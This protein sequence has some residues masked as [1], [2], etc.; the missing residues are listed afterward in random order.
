MITPTETV[1]E[2]ADHSL[3]IPRVPGYLGPA[4]VLEF[5]RRDRLVLVQWEDRGQS[6][7]SWAAPALAGDYQFVA[8]DIVLVLSQNLADFY[9]TGLLHS[10]LGRARG[11]SPSSIRSASGAIA[12]VSRDAHAETLAVRSPR[13]E[14]VFEYEPESG[15]TRVHVPA[16]DLEFVA[17]N[18]SI[19]FHSGKDIR[20]GAATVSLLSRWGAC[21]GIFGTDG[22]VKSSITLEPE[23]IRFKTPELNAEA[24]QANLQISKTHLTGRSV[25]AKV[26]TFH[27]LSHR[28]ESLTE[29][30]I[31]KARNVYRTAEQLSQTQAGRLRTI[32]SDLCHLKAR[33]VNFKAEEDFKVNGDKI[34][35]G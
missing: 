33:K 19:A 2:P 32:V 22:K 7:R 8:G 1:P 18:G 5:N 21:L 17:P 23:G 25:S 9:I 30:L 26:D 35:L 28:F 15:K 3:Q 11:Q 24:D 27:L 14:L 4:Q 29:T 13:G 12:S 20:F 6:C 31:E 16:G 34:H 10:H